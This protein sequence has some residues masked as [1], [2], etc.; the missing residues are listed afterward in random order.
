M[1]VEGFASCCCDMSVASLS[2][3]KS[4]KIGPML[5]VSLSISNEPQEYAK[6]AKLWTEI[7]ARADKEKEA[8]GLDI[9]TKKGETSSSSSAASTATTT[10]R[11]KVVAK[12]I[13]KVNQTSLCNLWADMVHDSFRTYMYICISGRGLRSCLQELNP[14]VSC[15]KRSTSDSCARRRV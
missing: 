1:P 2:R 9:V 8:G 3:S 10:S 5:I 11:Q 14:H 15:R 6:R 13:Q 7:H 12:Q 4:N